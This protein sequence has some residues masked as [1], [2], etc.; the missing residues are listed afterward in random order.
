[1]KVLII[2]LGPN[3][4]DRSKFFI[5]NDGLIRSAVHKD[6]TPMPYSL[7]DYDKEILKYN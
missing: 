1:M 6:F 2:D 3:Y 7:K 5:F 4:F